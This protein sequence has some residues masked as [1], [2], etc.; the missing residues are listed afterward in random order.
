MNSFASQIATAINVAD[1]QVSNAVELIT[2]GATIPFIARYRKERTG[3]LTD[4]ELLELE[5]LYNKHLQLEDRKKTV[6]KSLE[7]QGVITG[8]LKE[9]VLEARLLAEVEDI[10]LPFKP[11]RKTRAVIARSKGLEP[12]AKMIMS[13]TLSNVE[14]VAQ[15]YVS[16][17]S[18]VDNI[19]DALSG[20][21]DIIAEWVS[22]RQWVRQTL[23]A[24]FERDSILSSKPVKGKESDPDR[25]RGEK[26]KAWFDWKE[27]AKKAPPHRI[28]AMFRGEKEGFL[29]LKIQ[30]ELE[31]AIHILTSRLLK[32]NNESSNQKE[33]AIIDSIKRFLFPSLETEMRSNLK[34]KADEASIKVFS[35]NLQQLLLS[36]P[37]G[38][39]RVLAID[40]GFRTGC[41]I[42]CLD[43]NGGLLHNDTIYPHPPQRDTK[44]AMKKINNLIDSHKIEAIAIGNGTAGRETEQL[45][46]RMK[47]N[48][49][50][51][52]VMVN[53]DGASVYSA[54]SSAREEFP[55]YDITVRGAVSIGRRLL[56]PLAEL[57]KIDPKSIGVGQYQHDV[58]QKLLKQ[59]L[60]STVELCVN[61]VGVDL[62]TASKELLTYVSGLGPKLAMQII[63]YRNANGNF[64]NREELKK[65]TGLGN[66]AFQQ[67]AG[68]LRIKDGDN[69]LDS[70]A[71]HPEHYQI[72][73]KIAKNQ[74]VKLEQLIGNK[75]LRSAITLEELADNNVGLL[76]LKDIIDE[77]E[78]P[79]RDPRKKFT[80]FKFD[81]NINSISD[82]SVGKVLKGTVTNITAF[83]AFID[84][85]I[86]ES[87]LLHKSQ[88]ANEYVS[89][90][91]DYLRINQPVTVKVL[92][93]DI[94]RK[95]IGLSMKDV[96]QV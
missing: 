9:Q 90:P 54:S 94:E 96:K 4:I 18:G 7:E 53:E 1:W 64:K 32:N 87:A 12:L 84:L 70:T 5:K 52:A 23:R 13:E 27:I 93:V 61:K 43:E 81:S 80:T 56:D 3:E 19:G 60:Q 39:K 73:K 42:V 26:Y 11:K 44:I 85:G 68:F 2:E 16:A 57:V 59:G 33:L 36:P 46:E 35:D 83:G 69:I 79:G 50:I 8:E 92:E 15:K 82:L 25:N 38:Q 28:L 71:V 17:K 37:M 67:A 51:I 95:R 88:I 22:E 55:E 34:E 48:R 30:P 10:Y 72:V 45:I 86:K 74:G 89:N 77:L 29:K 21:R 24:L 58:N 40:P 63:D 75:Q 91:S 31:T 49:D 66:K 78:K 62:N 6:L 76:T 20:A 41:K 65:V 14:E 47:F